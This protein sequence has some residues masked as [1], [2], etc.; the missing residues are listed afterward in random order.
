MDKSHLYWKTFWAHASDAGDQVRLSARTVPNSRD[1]H[2]FH[3]R[4]DI[5][6]FFFSSFLNWIPSQFQADLKPRVGDSMDI[7]PSQ[8]F[9]RWTSYPR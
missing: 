8:Y 7:L 5:E 1:S 9:F 4:F 2:L 6:P 3:D